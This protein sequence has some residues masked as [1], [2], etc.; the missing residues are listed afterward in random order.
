MFPLHVLFYRL[1]MIIG[2]LSEAERVEALH[3]AFK[4]VFDF[5]RATDFGDKPA[6]RIVLDGDRVFVNL[7][8]P[9]GATRDSQLLETHRRYID[10][11]VP[12]DAPEEIG[13][14]PTAEIEHVS[15]PYDDALDRAFSDDRPRFFAE[16]HPG[17]FCVV[18]PE[19]AHAP[20]ISPRPFRKLVAKVKV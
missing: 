19:D 12:L 10:I 5:I 16:L 15:H 18:F 13:W 1:I 2:K 9:Q 3:P 8:E 17:E 7:D 6:G 11:H 4:A 20:A 14:K